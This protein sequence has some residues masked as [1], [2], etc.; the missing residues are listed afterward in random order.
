MIFK[1][2]PIQSEKKIPFKEFS[3]RK[4]LF[5]KYS[6]LICALAAPCFFANPLSLYAGSLTCIANAN[7]ESKNTGSNNIE[8]Y[9]DTL[10]QSNDYIDITAEAAI[11]YDIDNDRV[12]WQKNSLEKMFPASTTKMLTAIVAIER[13]RDFDEIV[14]ISANASGRNNSFFPFRAGQEI[15]LRDLLK[16]ALISSHNNATVALAEYV[17]GSEE[18]FL[19]LMNAK[20]I[21]IGA[22]NTYFESTNGLDSEYPQ[23]NT[24]AYDLALIADYCME[25]EMF[26]EIVGTKEDTITLGDEKLNLYNTNSLLFFDYI[27]GIK[28]GFTNNAGHCLAVFSERQE[29]NLII[30]VLKCSEGSR[31]ADAL[32][33][34]NWANDNFF[35]K[36]ILEPQEKYKTIVIQD[37]QTEEKY[38]LKTTHYTELYTNGDYEQLVNVKDDIAI[39]D[40]LKEFNTDSKNSIVYIP[41]TPVV[42][43]VE[44]GASAGQAEIYVNDNKV[45][46]SGLIINQS[47]DKTYVSVYLSSEFNSNTRNI[48][49]A[50]ISFY[51]LI[52]I[53]III[54][55]FISKKRENPY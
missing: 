1:T 34:I 40:D 20:A 51:F 10:A 2:N 23:H 55:N 45:Y 9:A 49:I 21:E 54:K 12:L 28:T 11:I 33:L 36:K 27:K 50:L 16:A 48:L 46:T 41:Q 17:S 24:T 30:I 22:F 38:V 7:I 5:L 39:K 25:N 31:E 32:K 29:L 8:I 14:R 53:F 15:T 43:P 44:K 52:F 4:S 35:T 26:S 18:Q 37:V 42:L 47:I 3:S 19:K 6:F 13:I